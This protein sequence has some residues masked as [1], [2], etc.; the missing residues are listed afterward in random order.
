M[1]GNI[2]PTGG[3]TDRADLVAL[4]AGVHDTIVGALE[5]ALGAD[6]AREILYWPLFEAGRSAAAAERRDAAAIAREIMNLE[7]RFGLRG[8]LLEEGPERT[9][10]EVT[11]CPWLGVR[12]ISCRVFAWWM[13]G[14][15]QGLNPAFR[16]RLQQLVPEGAATCIWSISRQEERQNE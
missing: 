15:C 13:E 12:P 3:E 16:Y 11:E 7:E 1:S 4:W 2:P 10:R 9:V 8:R 14:F 6:R 5:D